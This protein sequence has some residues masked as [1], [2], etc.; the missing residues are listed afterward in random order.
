MLP[1]ARITDPTGHPGAIVPGGGIRTVL[2][3][4]LSAASA[5][6]LNA[7]A[8]PPLAGP[9]GTVPFTGGSATVLIGGSPALRMTDKAA[10]GAPIVG[11]FPSVLIGG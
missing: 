2:I 7:C 4:G 10:C 3:G 11:G 9:H 8:M 5:L 1:A 6:D